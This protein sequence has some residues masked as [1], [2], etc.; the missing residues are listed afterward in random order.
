M[1]ENQARYQADYKTDKDVA[2]ALGKLGFGVSTQT[3]YV[4][5]EHEFFLSLKSIATPTYEF[6][7]WQ[8]INEML[9][10]FNQACNI[11]LASS[12]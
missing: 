9:D 8:I 7:F 11:Y 5:R 4:E 12:F 1:L 3:I 2:S 10:I 6:P